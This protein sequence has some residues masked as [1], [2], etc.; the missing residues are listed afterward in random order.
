MS[1]LMFLW[2]VSLL[3]VQKSL[4]RRRDDGDDSGVNGEE[5]KLDQAIPTPVMADT[6]SRDSTIR[7]GADE[8][9]VPAR[10]RA[11]RGIASKI[12]RTATAVTLGAV[13]TWSALAYS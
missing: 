7:P 11:R 4:K 6:A 12:F 13:V 1:F 2:D 3:H 5:N 9:A 8:V 10:K